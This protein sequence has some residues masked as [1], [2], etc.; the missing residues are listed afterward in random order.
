MRFGTGSP[1]LGGTDALQEAI[2]RRQTG[3]AGAISQVGGAA[4]TAQPMPMAP[5]MGG[6]P[7]MAP[8]APAPMGLPQGPTDS[9]II[10]KALSARLQSDSKI[11]E[12]QS[13][14]PK[15]TPA[16]TPEPMTSPVQGF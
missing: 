13:I 7:P 3:E 8:E 6:M 10:L 11:K 2:A 16:P 12:S 9:E 5:E 14:P 4:P 1:L 15:P